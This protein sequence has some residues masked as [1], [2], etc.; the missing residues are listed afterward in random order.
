MRGPT[1][2]PRERLRITATEVRAAELQPGDLFSTAGPEYW[3]ARRPPGAVG[4]KV[5]IRT[6]A[7]C[8]RGEENEVVFRLDIERRRT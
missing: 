3:T 5:Y 2:A 6:E 8:P 4:E 1:T 7:P